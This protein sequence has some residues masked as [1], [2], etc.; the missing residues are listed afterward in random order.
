[1]LSHGCPQE[2]QYRQPHP[3]VALAQEEG[4]T[5]H[6]GAQGG[7]DDGQLRSLYAIL[8][9]RISEVTSLEN[10]I[11]SHLMGIAAE[12]SRLLGGQLVQV[13]K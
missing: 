1:M 3:V 8:T 6:H 10:S 11:E 2:V 13:H 7:G 5:D 9:G 4:V 12:E